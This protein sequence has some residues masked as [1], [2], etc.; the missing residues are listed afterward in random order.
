MENSPRSQLGVFRI[1][2]S[3]NP[4]RRIIILA[5][6][7]EDQQQFFSPCNDCEHGWSSTT[8]NCRD[9]SFFSVSFC[10]I[11]I[12]DH[13]AGSLPFSSDS[14]AP[15]SSFFR[16][17]G[18]RAVPHDIQQSPLFPTEPSCRGDFKQLDRLRHSGGVDGGLTEILD[19]SLV[20][21]SFPQNNNNH[22]FH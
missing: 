19:S 13:A 17:L 7:D 21:S 3:K 12:F 2:R 10:R 14:S 22:S 11:E 6:H 16:L 4:L 18:G 5:H 15:S 1:A 9:S 8:A 20:F